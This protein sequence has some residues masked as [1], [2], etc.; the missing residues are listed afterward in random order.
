ML[1]YMPEGRARTSSVLV[2]LRPHKG[3][4]END[5]RDAQDDQE[6]VMTQMFLNHLLD[7]D[8]LRELMFSA[9]SRRNEDRPLRAGAD[10]T[11]PKTLQSVVVEESLFSKGQ[12]LLELPPA[13]DASGSDLQQFK[14]GLDARRALLPAFAAPG[15]SGW[16][17]L[18][19]LPLYVVL[20][21]PSARSTRSP[22]ATPLE[23][24]AVGQHESST[25]LAHLRRSGFRPDL[26]DLVFVV[27]ASLG[28]C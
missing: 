7:Y 3:E 5:C 25:F 21:R 16:F 24:V 22:V 4:V 14:P 28:A 15:S 8:T 6:S 12:R 13:V 26:A 20:C 18:F 9:T 23:S 2:P 19:V 10:G 27:V 1:S 17:L 11:I